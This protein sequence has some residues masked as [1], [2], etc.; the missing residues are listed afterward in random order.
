MEITRGRTYLAGH[1]WYQGTVM[2]GRN[3]FAEHLSLVL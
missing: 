1:C 3:D 2:K